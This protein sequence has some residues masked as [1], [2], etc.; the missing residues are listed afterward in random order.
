[1]NENVILNLHNF[2]FHSNIKVSFLHEQWFDWPNCSIDTNTKIAFFD[3]WL[4]TSHHRIRACC[5]SK[6]HSFRCHETIAT[7]KK[8]DG[9]NHTWQKNWS[10]LHFHFEHHS[11]RGWSYPGMFLFFKNE[12][13]QNFKISWK[14]NIDI[15]IFYNR[16]T[17]HCNEFENANWL[18][19]FHGD[20]QVFKWHYPGNLHMC[21]VLIVSQD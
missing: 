8:Y 2:L 15:A 7:T 6:N 1:M 13:S 10:L 5:S 14:T 4:Y 20:L 17:N 12:F 18:D 11:R 19:S 16:Y 3:D 9:V 21:Q